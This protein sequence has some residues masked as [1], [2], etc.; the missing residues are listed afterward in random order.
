[1]SKVWV[2]VQLVRDASE[3]ELAH[4][5]EETVVICARVSSFLDRPDANAVYA[6][7]VEAMYSGTPNTHENA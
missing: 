5:S 4:G 3:A 6:R 2:R 1:M 7:A